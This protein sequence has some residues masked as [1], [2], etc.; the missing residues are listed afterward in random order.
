MKRTLEYKLFNAVALIITTVF[1]LACLYPLLIT[2]AGSFTPDKEL[3]RG[4][5]LIPDNPT[6]SAY[7]AIFANP[8]KMIRAYG[9][10]ISLVICGTVLGLF[11]STMT[12]YVLYR[13]DFV[14][15]NFFALYFYFTTLFSGG[16]IPSYI[17]HC[18]LGL[19]NTYW[20]LLLQG[21]I[22][23]FQFIMIRSY[24]T[25]N[26][27]FTM[28]EAAKI[29]GANDFQIYLRVVMPSCKAIMATIGLMTA[30]TYWNQWYTC[31]IYI[32]NDKL[33][34]LQYFLQ[35]IFRDAKI[36]EELIAA[37]A[38]DMAGKIAAVGEGYKMAMTIITIGPVILFYPMIQKY[39]VSGATIGAVKE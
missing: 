23:N 30:M 22:S 4:I 33:F 15:R 3:F 14:A 9:V 1:A 8:L 10:T 20:V 18:A 5:R 21:L 36:R 19:R 29:D 16:L 27:P 34:T 12:G 2:L 31:S 38:G 17:L 32:S 26:I 11:F 39:V 37:G 13:K 25:G 6:L 35:K 24:L 28:I 7:K